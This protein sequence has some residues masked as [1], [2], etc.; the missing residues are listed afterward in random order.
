MIHSGCLSK[1]NTKELE[2]IITCGAWEEVCTQLGKMNLLEQVVGVFHPDINQIVSQEDMHA[3]ISWGQDGED[4][5][6]TSIFSKMIDSGQKGVYVDVGAHH[7]Y[8]FSNTYWAY[9]RGWTGVNIEPDQELF[10]KFLTFRPKDINVNAGIADKTGKMKYYVYEEKACNTFDENLYR[11]VLK[12]VEIR[13]IPVQKLKDVLHT[14][15]MTEIDFMSIDVEGYEM[16]V[17]KSNDW[18]QF[19]PRIL[20]VEQYLDIKGILESEIYQFL[21]EH[22]Y[23][24]SD[25]YHR[26]AIYYDKTNR[27]M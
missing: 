26:T 20:L 14:H 8:R 1:F 23:C 7:P 11:D 15:K 4:I 24:L 9:Q 16:D 19:R 21:T 6:L 25:K 5:L 12:P 27:V 22:D 18:K 13:D 3:V 2:I 17:L 10:Q